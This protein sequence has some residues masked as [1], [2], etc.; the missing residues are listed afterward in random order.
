MIITFVYFGFE[1]FTA[2]VANILSA[3]AVISPGK[4][5]VIHSV[6]T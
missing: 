6:I 4:L 5:K 2:V 3:D 1:M